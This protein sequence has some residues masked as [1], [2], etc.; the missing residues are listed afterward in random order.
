MARILT[1]TT[2]ILAEAAKALRTGELVAF[3]TETV[4]GL[5]ANAADDTAVARI[6][7]A[8]GRPSFNPL[9]VH[10]ASLDAARAHVVFDERA[11]K[12]AAAFW[13]GPL[14]M[15]LPRRED[16]PLS[17]LVSAGL[18]TVAIRLPSHPL[19]RTLIAQADVPVAAP[20]ANRSGSISPTRARHVAESLG[21]H[22]DMVLDGGSCDVGVESTVIDLSTPIAG[23]L[24]PGGITRR[25]VEDL[26]G[27]LTLST[28]SE[29]APKSPG[30]MLNHYAPGLP[31]RLNAEQAKDGETLLGFGTVEGNPLT[32][33]ASGD[34]VEAAANLFAMLH[35]LDDATRFRG[36]AVAPIPTDGLGLAINDR[37]RRAAAPRMKTR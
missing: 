25:Q 12:L 10:Y 3:P 23:L 9:I 1:P 7:Q 15:V 5:G 35:Q 36:I 2:D 8:K 37:L 34:L 24:R 19:A 27:P 33:S 13:P 17:R 21:D 29:E 26:I 32:L 4:Y 30:Q 18:P 31:V 14:T 20:S 22:I 11:E 6:Y 16:C 28:D